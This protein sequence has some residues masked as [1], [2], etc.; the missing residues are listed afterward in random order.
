M[1]F[2]NLRNLDDNIQSS[3]IWCFAN[4]EI[5]CYAT[6]PFRIHSPPTYQHVA[7]VVVVPE[8]RFHLY[9]VYSLFPPLESRIYNLDLLA[10]PCRRSASSL[11]VVV[12][13]RRESRQRSWKQEILKHR[14]TATRPHRRLR[15]RPSQDQV[16]CI[17]CSSPRWLFITHTLD[18]CNHVLYKYINAHFCENP[19]EDNGAEHQH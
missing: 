9:L 18:M 7:K 1:M 15:R 17:C 14:H 4:L 12:G 10:M 8:H 13:V 19:L 3:Q 5:W 16:I 11:V 6:T 2:C